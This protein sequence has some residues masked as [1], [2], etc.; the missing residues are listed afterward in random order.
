MLNATAI[1]VFAQSTSSDGVRK[2]LASQLVVNRRLLVQLNERTLKTAEATGLP[3]ICSSAL[4][5][6]A[7]TFGEQLTQAVRA[8]FALGFDRVLVIGNDCPA[9]TDVH[10]LQAV[11][12]LQESSVVIGP[13]CRGGL[14]LFGVSREAFEAVSLTNLPWQTNQ[15]AQAI[16]HLF[17][18]QASTSLPRLGDI[19][20]LADLHHYQRSTTDVT[21]F[22]ARLLTLAKGESLQ[23]QQPTSSCYWGIFNNT[24]SL[25]APPVQY[26]PVTAA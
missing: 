13:D 11:N 17:G 20:S 15:L 14:Y 6:H 25:R 7:G 1:L 12:Q 3:V 8:T 24:R 23:F 26:A 9:L 2:R 19:N 16:R 22:I 21:S 18:N 4:I 5:A 10:I